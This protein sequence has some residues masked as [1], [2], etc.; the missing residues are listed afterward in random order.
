LSCVFDKTS[1]TGL[2]IAKLALDD[3]EL[4]LNLGPDRGLQM[5]ESINN[6]AEAFGFDGFT[7]TTLHGDVPSG[8]NVLGVFT[9]FN[10]DVTSVSAWR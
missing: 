7:L 1:V 8:F 3:S 10:T 6:V 2:A 5:L 9:L 4:M